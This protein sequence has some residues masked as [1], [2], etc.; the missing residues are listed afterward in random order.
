MPIGSSG[1]I[2]IYVRSL[3]LH[4]GGG[5]LFDLSYPG[6]VFLFSI[7]VINREILDGDVRMNRR[8]RSRA[9]SYGLNRLVCDRM[10]AFR[11]TICFLH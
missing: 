1:D 8:S 4:G 5:R 10:H 3:D 11:A 6:A 7:S 9:T 2:S